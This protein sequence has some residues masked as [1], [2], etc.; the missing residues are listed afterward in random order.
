MNIKFTVAAG[1]VLLSSALLN[2]QAQAALITDGF[3]FAVADSCDGIGGH[4]H[5]S[6]GGDFGNPAGKAEVGSYS[7]EEV[8]G[9]SEYDITGLVAVSSAF[10]SFEV[11]SA[12]GLF[13]GT[14]DFPFSGMIGIDAYMGNNLENISD[15]NIASFGSVGQFST[16]ILF[17][18][19]TLSFDITALFNDAIDAGFASFGIRLFATETDNEGAWTFDNF[20]LTSD[21]LTTPGPTP[22]PEPGVLFMFA[23]A[24]I[25]LR[26]FR[27]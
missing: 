22:V 10:V 21:D 7:C 27:R 4:Y 2:N 5:S 24:L 20:R 8:R 18:G 12:G 1:L 16:D 17:V 26:L 25:M 11:F 23:S 15:F 14:N 6:T 3:T 19:N 9:L 13:S